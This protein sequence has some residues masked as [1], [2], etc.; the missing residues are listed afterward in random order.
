MKRR[1]EETKEYPVSD[2][3][4]EQTNDLVI[5]RRSHERLSMALRENLRKRKAQS[6]VRAN[7]ETS[8]PCESHDNQ[9]EAP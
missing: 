6:K 9:N 7:Q 3:H 2:K 1:T 4:K 8:Q 5:K